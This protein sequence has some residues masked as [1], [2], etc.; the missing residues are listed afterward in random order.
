[1]RTASL[2]RLSYGCLL[3]FVT[4]LKAADLAAP[5]EYEGKPVEEIRFIPAVQPLAPA[6]L[7]R[8][9]NLHPGQAIHLSDV[10]DLI[11]HMYASGL[12]SDIEVDTEPSGNGLAVVIRTTE[13]W[14]VGPYE[15]RGKLNNPPNAGQLGNAT[16]L[17]LGAPF[18]DEDI[19]NAQKG[20]TD[21]LQRNGLYLSE[22]NPKIT[23]DAEHQEV[24]ITFQ[25]NSGKRARL[26]TPVIKGDTKIPP[27]KV[28]KYAKY[29][30]LFRWKPAT[31]DNTQ[32][33]LRN[34]RSKYDKQDR[35]TAEVTLDDT[36]YLPDQKRVQPV[37]TAEG[38]PKIKIQTSGA[39]MSKGKLE[40]YVPVFDEETVN[41]DLLVRGVA[42]LR[43]YFQLKGYFD[44]G[45]N[46]TTKQ[47]DPDHENIT[48]TVGLGQRKKLVRVDVRGNKYF[49][50][51]DIR[52]RMFLHPNGL[53]RLR[54]GRYSK[55]FADTDKNNITALY[56]ANGFRD[57]KITINTIEN[58]KNKK[59]DVAVAFV[60]NE[61]PQYLVSKV[62]VEGI[63]RTDKQQMISRMATRPGEPF[64]ETNVALDRDYILTVYQS[65]GYPNANFVWQMVKGPGPNQVS[66]QYTVTEGQPA[67][68]RDVLITGMRATSPRLV[69]PNITLQRGEP[70]SWTQMGRMQRNLYNLGVFD[71]VD[72]AIQ[73]P[74]GDT[75]QKYV[76]FHLVE[77]HRWYTAVGFG[78]ELARFGGSQTSLNNST[79]ATGLAP[80]VDLEVSRL[81]M[82]G[83]GHSINFKG[84]YSTLDRQVQLNYL[85]PRFH[86]V[87]GR[88][89][90]V[91]ALYDNERDVL[92]F[93]ARRVQ[94]SVQ[95]SQKFSKATTALFRYQWENDTVDQSTLK[96]N[97]LLIPLASQPANMGMLAANI[98]Q[99]RRD[100]PTD[101]HR[102]IYNSADVGV[103]ERYFGGNKNFT[104]LLLR[105]SYYKTVFTDDV[106]ASNTE[107]GWI[108][109]FSRPT[110]VDP[111]DYVPIP[112]HFFGGGADSMRGFPFNEA[113]PRDP[114]T[115]FPLGG[116]A[117]F[118]HS[119]EFR[120]PLIGDN[121]GGVFFHD[122]GNVYTDLRSISFR[123]HQNSL[124]D[125][126][127]MVHAVGFGIRY[128]TP[129]GPVR[130]D[131]AYSINPPSFHGL[132]GT[133]QQLLF[134]GA[135]PTT[136]S[137]SHFQ[138]FISIGQA[139]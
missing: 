64:S 10:R 46:F 58:Y 21:L 121:I 127:Y 129:L 75:E 18:S 122:M 65:A 26:T 97:P 117:L 74:D 42:N 53:I 4:F 40:K 136:R 125:F 30:G 138:F 35:L 66:V 137:V 135:T 78:A 45:V 118:F 19:Q 71:K 98:I 86:N 59:G 139:F 17:Q 104:R 22:I 134:G 13:Q 111:L 73:N 5:S 68:V 16:Q 34:I 126:D 31:E 85:A 88:N 120:F 91:T 69:N 107:F 105:N 82:W 54:H 41:R 80:R 2:R 72:M 11:K 49:K 130:A 43:D 110:G 77:G 63:T 62:D 33:G 113:G 36:K 94:G 38:G 50:T 52:E 3:F 103:V 128:R 132:E 112:E 14:F 84:R 114:V 108:H 8:I 47:V 109:T 28:A 123:V 89:I 7:K 29:K 32:R 76:L 95:L 79:G 20:V 24:S 81:N 133:Y 60:I 70:L 56:R 37:I 55:G 96:I 67:F 92:T 101:A 15:V 1:M 12:Y 9:M 57:I 119:T 100:D 23:R 99:D 106:I 61:G 131:F 6:D 93:T 115:G 44:V 25:V 102:G 39:K 90:S 87:D 48:Y 124:T 116:N 83:L 27:E 51:A